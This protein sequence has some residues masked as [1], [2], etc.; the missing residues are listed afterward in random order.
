[1]DIVYGTLKSDVINNYLKNQHKDLKFDGDLQKGRCKV[2]MGYLS[3]YL[4]WDTNDVVIDL[5]LK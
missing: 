4:S 2:R 5:W 3:G 1:M